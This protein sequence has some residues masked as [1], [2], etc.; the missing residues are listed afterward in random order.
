MLELGRWENGTYRNF[1]K[2]GAG[3]YPVRVVEE[4]GTDAGVKIPV[5]GTGSAGKGRAY[6]TLGKTTF[7]IPPWEISALG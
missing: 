4:G 3:I 6:S 7:P 5:L 2:N 1:E